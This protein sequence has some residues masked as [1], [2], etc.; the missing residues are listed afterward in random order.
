MASIEEKIRRNAASM[1]SRNK[2]LHEMQEKY[3][4][5]GR[6]N[7][8]L[9]SPLD[10][11]EWIR[12]IVDTSPYDAKRGVKRALANL[13][14]NI[15]IHPITVMRAVEGDD[16]SSEAK[17]KANQWETILK[18]T[19]SKTAK[20]RSAF[21][22][23]VIDSAALYHEIVGQLI[24][25]PTQLKAMGANGNSR[26]KAALRYGDWAIKLVNPQT[27]NVDYSDYMLERVCSINKKTAQEIVDFWGDAASKIAAKIK[28]NEEYGNE[29]LIEV[30][31]VD[32]DN[33]MVWIIEEADN[34]EDDEGIIVLGP[35]PWLTFEG[36]PVP[37]L[38]WVAVAGGTD[39][40][41][42]PEHQ[43]QPLFY[44]V[45]MAEQ[46]ANANIMGT[47]EMS[48]AIA[49]ANAPEQ[50][51]TSA[52]GEDGVVTDHEE[53]GGILR[54][55]P[56]ETYQQI[57]RQGLD[58][59]LMESYDRLRDA[60][61][62]ATVA[63]I[64]VTGQPMGGVEAF[65][66]Y[67]LQV[68]IAISSLGDFKHLGERFYEDAIEKILLITHYTG[69]EI[70]GYGDGLD[71]YVIDSEDIDPEVIHVSVELKP[72][73]P[74]DRQQRVVTAAT[75]AR[76][77][78]VPTRVILEWLGES[79]PEGLMREWKK[80][81]MFQAYFS[82]L[83]QKVQMA[84]S[85]ELQQLMQA[86]QQGQALA[87]QVQQAQAGMYQ[88]RGVPGVGGQEVNPAEG[89]VPPATL[90]PQATRELQTGRDRFG[91]MVAQPGEI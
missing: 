23:S 47:I 45:A 50:V 69:G 11:F 2:R 1:A 37:F 61:K 3:E 66:A 56:G 40:D 58:P 91:N 22:D 80:E 19:L 14:M 76:D 30:D 13:E 36:K 84:G 18:W 29:V 83:L 38:P 62:S 86:A 74:A 70:S 6:I 87:E 51:I 31:Y 35:E 43:R 12:P 44:P 48:A 52:R 16:E 41:T 20:R 55:L 65:A 75:M 24:H 89:G 28:K 26:S 79:D 59:A 33:R 17:K 21:Y 42:A 72:D 9:P 57:R 46:W 25:I 34:L 68:Q 78:K 85:G 5:M 15:N 32:Y 67:N 90:A 64:L 54:L 27:V 63:D 77:M 4:Q 82:G 7:Y 8:T 73:V 60:I 71:K 88:E 10:K 53:P 49:T 39:I 81:Q